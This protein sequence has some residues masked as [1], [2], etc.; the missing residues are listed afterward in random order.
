MIFNS[1]GFLATKFVHSS[2]SIFPSW[3]KSAS[4]KV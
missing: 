2:M 1:D 3:F 4:E